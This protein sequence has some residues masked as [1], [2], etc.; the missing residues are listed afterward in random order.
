MSYQRQEKKRNN[1]AMKKRVEG[2][3]QIFPLIWERKQKQIKVQEKLEGDKNMRTK[4]EQAFKQI[5]KL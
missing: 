4:F 3:Y 2:E 1:E 5:Q